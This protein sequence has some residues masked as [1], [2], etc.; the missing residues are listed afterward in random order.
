[1]TP[2]SYGR[3]SVIVCVCVCVVMIEPPHTHSLS[4]V[5][6]SWPTALVVRPYLIASFSVI[7]E[8]REAHLQ[9][10]GASGE[11]GGR[12]ARVDGGADGLGKVRWSAKGKP[13]NGERGRV[14]WWW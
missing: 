10:E 9:L 11:E 1:M 7:F 2:V 5:P 6:W 13:A 3:V 14:K 8:V 12:A 4:A